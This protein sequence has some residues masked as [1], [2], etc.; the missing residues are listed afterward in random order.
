MEVPSDFKC[1]RCPTNCLIV[2]PSNV[3]KTHLMKEIIKHREYLFDKEIGRIVW[4]YSEENAV[5]RELENVEFYEGAPQLSDFS[6][7]EK[8]T[9]L[10]LDDLMQD[11]N[12]QVTSFFLKGSHHRN[13]CVFLLIQNL[14]NSKIRQISLNS[15]TVIVFKQKRDMSQVRHFCMQH[16]PAHWRK[17]FAAYQDVTNDAGHGYLL[18][19]FH[20][21]TPDFLRY[22]TKILPYEDNT[23]YVVRKV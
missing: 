4:C 16:D 14:Y 9:I 6:P 3:G 10:V 21:K 1:F 17:I 13:L 15:S 22:R 23:V 12:D 2:G 18:F 7:T 11:V 8:P 5:P 20:P 19:D